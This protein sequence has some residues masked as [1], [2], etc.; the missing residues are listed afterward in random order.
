MIPPVAPIIRLIR[1]VAVPRGWVPVLITVGLFHVIRA[2][3]LGQLAP[4]ELIEVI[5]RWRL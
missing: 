2:L 3:Q 4:D 1:G 5:P